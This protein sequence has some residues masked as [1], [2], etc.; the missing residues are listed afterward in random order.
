[1]AVV[2]LALPSQP[3]PGTAAVQPPASIDDLVAHREGAYLLAV[4]MLG[5]A[6]D[7]EDA[8][9]QA[10]LQALAFQGARPRGDDAK[11]WFLAV[12]ANA[13][14][15][16]ATA[17]AAAPSASSVRFRPTSPRPRPRMAP[18]TPRACSSRRSTASTPSS[19]PPS[20]CAIRW[21]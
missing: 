12:V 19:A 1:M 11:R 16:R 7:A 10:Y 18:P 13:A 5:N 14:R 17:A 3:A 8:L 15:R 4:R 2:S 21:A 6:A 20:P 9:Q